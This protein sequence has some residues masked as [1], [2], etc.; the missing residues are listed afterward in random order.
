MVRT[1]SHGLLGLP[2][3]SGEEDVSGGVGH[4]ADTNQRYRHTA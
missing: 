3:F 2:F 4:G 1:A